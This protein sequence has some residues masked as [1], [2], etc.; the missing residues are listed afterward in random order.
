MA[1]SDPAN[2]KVET[3]RA[4]G[5]WDIYNMITRFIKEVG[6]PMAVAIAMFAYFWMIGRA[7]NDH[8]AA[9]AKIMERTVNVLERMEKKLP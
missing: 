5:M 8:L 2:T 4:G 7:T 3:K 9:G 6:F 1:E